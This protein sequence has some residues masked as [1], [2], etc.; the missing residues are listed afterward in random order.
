V[1]TGEVGESEQHVEVVGALRDLLGVV[2]V[3]GV[4]DL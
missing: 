3:F 1:L 2:A 4:V